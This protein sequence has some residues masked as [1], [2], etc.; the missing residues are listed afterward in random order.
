MAFR[1]YFVHK[2]EGHAR[3]FCIRY[4]QDMLPDDI[5]RLHFSGQVQFEEQQ[6][7]LR[8]TG[9]LYS[10]KPIGV[11]VISADRLPLS[12]RGDATLLERCIGD[13]QSA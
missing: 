3:G 11:L 1:L 13:Q 5:Y 6:K 10:S 4:S 7:V 2:S 12:D 9:C 8:K